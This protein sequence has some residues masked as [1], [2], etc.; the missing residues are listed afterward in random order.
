[1]FELAEYL[2]TEFDFQTM[3]DTREVYYYLDGKYIPRGE[4]LIEIEC[5]KAA[6]DVKT[7]VVREVIEIIRRTTP[8]ERDEFDKDIY[9]L[10]LQMAC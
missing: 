3:N 8:V 9:I 6:S 7:A 10:M 1:M 5:A 2:K 4:R